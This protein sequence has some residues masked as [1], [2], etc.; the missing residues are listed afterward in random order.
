MGHFL[1]MLCQA[2]SRETFWKWHLGL[3]YDIS[4]GYS[5]EMNSSMMILICWLAVLTG[6]PIIFHSACGHTAAQISH[7]NRVAAKQND[8]EGG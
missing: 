8:T 2:S 7:H 5:G 4:Y 1:P 6:G 3:I